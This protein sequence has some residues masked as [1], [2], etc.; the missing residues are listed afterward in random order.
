VCAERP[1]AVKGAPL[2]GAAKRTL[3]GGEDRSA[4]IPQE[5]MAL[6]YIV[7]AKGSSFSGGAA[8]L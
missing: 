7:I 2:F 3:D 8:F 1:A 5:G 4:R 6:T